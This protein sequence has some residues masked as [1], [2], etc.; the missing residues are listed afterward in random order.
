MSERPPKLPPAALLVV[1]GSQV[2]TLGEKVVWYHDW[3]LDQGGPDG[4]YISHASL[5]AR[6]GASLSAATISTTRQRLKRLTL[7]HALVRADARNLGWVSV[8]PVGFTPRIPKEAAGLAVALDT[9]LR[10]LEAWVKESG[11]HAPDS[12]VRPYQVD[13]EPRTSPPESLATAMG[14][15]GGLS[16]AVPKR[17]TPLSSAVNSTSEK[18]DEKGVG[19]LAP[20]DEKRDRLREEWAAWTRLKA[21]CTLS[22]EDNEL[23]QAYQARLKRRET[24]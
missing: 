21:G 22:P 7:H 5:S 12:P 1:W 16:S 3:T 17:E 23:V 4:S 11:R 2:L 13:R 8:L 24:A 19:A 20:Q 15:L 18:R 6:L 10:K 14:G 9:H